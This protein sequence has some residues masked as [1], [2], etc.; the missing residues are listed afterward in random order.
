MLLAAATR[1]DAAT[2]RLSYSE[3]PATDID[4]HAV[5]I[6]VA[7]I[8]EMCA[9][10]RSQTQIAP[11]PV[12]KSRY[13]VG[14][15]R[16]RRMNT[17]QE[18]VDK[19]A[20]KAFDSLIGVAESGWLDAKQSPY[21]LD[22]QKQKLELAKDITALANAAGGVIVIG[23]DTERH[24][25]T[26]AEQINKV[27]PFPL[28]LMDSDRCGKILHKLIHPPL[29]IRILL[30][31]NLAVD[32]YGVAAIVV[33]QGAEAPYLVANMLDEQDQNI[34]AYFGYFQ[35]KHDTIP[36][37]NIALIQQQ[38]SAGQQWT[39]IE[40]RLAAIEAIMA[41]WGKAGP[42]VK[43]VSQINQDR[44]NR[45]KSA[46]IAVQR[47][48]DPLVYFMASAEGECDFPALFKSR[49]ERV[50]RLIE[51]PPQLREHGF[52]IWAGDTAEIREGRFRRNV[53]VGQ[54]LIELWKDGLFIFIGPGDEDFLAWR[55]QGSD[56]PILVNNFALAESILMFCWLMKFIFDEAEPK[57]GSLRLVVG[58]DN[59][60][61][62]S[63]SARLSDVPEGKMRFG[64][65]AKSASA[66]SFEVSEVADL[67]HYDTEHVAYLLMA[68]IYNWFGFDANHV[69]YVDPSGPKPK[70]K[71]SFII[72]SPLPDTVATPGVF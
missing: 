9:R 44:D 65:Q 30:F 11:M 69:P 72:G 70:L 52:E 56:K 28:A 23:F 3:Q 2:W 25:T 38:L 5:F 18:V 47:D 43:S 55:M 71:G 31:E 33:P 62:P 29:E 45:L 61:R 50:V 12:S 51:K 64:G 27:C 22:T 1:E 57:P 19:L 46:R 68:D 26:A 32:G 60:T 34:G 24:P 35:R 10:A 48:G 40:Q 4:T 66:Q 53:L 17:P 36:S 16:L 67:T 20:A 41:S 42:P 49:M 63:G 15:N 58:F 14:D 13:I 54:R 6:I 21:V 8:A 39:S 37:P 59:L 7:Q